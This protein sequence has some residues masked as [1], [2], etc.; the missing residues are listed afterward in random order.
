[1][2]GADPRTRRRRTCGRGARIARRIPSPLS[3]VR[4]SRGPAPVAA[5]RIAGISGIGADSGNHAAAAMTDTLA[6]PAAFDLEVKHSRFRAQAAP[7]ASAADA[8][9][10]TVA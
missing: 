3:R 1:M 9:A 10:F 4:D 5:A 2:A 7:V 8:Q 6:A